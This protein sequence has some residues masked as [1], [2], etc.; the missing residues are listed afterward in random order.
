[1]GRPPG[2]GGRLLQPVA[3][4]PACTWLP[5]ATPAVGGFSSGFRRA[6]APRAKTTEQHRRFHPPMQRIEDEGPQWLASPLPLHPAGRRHLTGVQLTASSW[7]NDMCCVV[8]TGRSGERCSTW[9]W[10]W[11]RWGGA[12]LGKDGMAPEEP[13]TARWGEEAVDSGG[14]EK[15]WIGEEMRHGTGGGEDALVG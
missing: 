15:A 1:L 9:S 5:A 12:G 10:G 3:L 13:G 14:G 2:Q 6:T 7:Y 4:D 11:R 8:P